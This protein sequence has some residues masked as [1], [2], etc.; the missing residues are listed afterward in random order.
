M[1]YFPFNYKKT[2]PRKKLTDVSALYENSMK[3]DEYSVL[4]CCYLLH[5][6]LITKRYLISFQNDAIFNIIHLKFIL[7]LFFNEAEPSLYFFKTIT[8][9]VN[10]SN[11]KMFLLVLCTLALGKSGLH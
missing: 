5:L 7:L 4:I 11:H 10:E 8:L 2:S 6:F 1:E 3:T 9:H